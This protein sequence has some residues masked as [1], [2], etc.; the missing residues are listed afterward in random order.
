MFDT[1]AG[2]PVHPLVVHAVVV[3]GPLAALL[4]V[5]YT[6]RPRWRAGLKWP[7]L[8]VSAAAAVSA[9]AA[10]QSGEAL[11]ERVGDPAYEHAEAGD[12]A[13]ISVYVLLAAVVLLVFWLARPGVARV[14]ALAVVVVLLASG[15]LVFGVVSAG[16]SGAKS[17]WHGQIQGSTVPDEG[18][19]GD[20]DD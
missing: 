13:A 5:L 2:I 7:T 11:E 3:L 1:V 4:A 10:T 18:D 9:F 19:E 8:L 12:L 17:V 6:V 16:H 14:G 20:E 15:F